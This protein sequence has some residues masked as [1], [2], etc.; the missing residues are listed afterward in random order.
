MTDKLP[1][2]NQINAT[3]Q[4]ISEADLKVLWRAYKAAG[5]QRCQESECVLPEHHPGEH[6]PPSETW[7]PL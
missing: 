4:Q 7:S 3:L 1:S 6:R 5:F 2:P